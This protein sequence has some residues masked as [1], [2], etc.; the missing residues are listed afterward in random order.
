MTLQM[1]VIRAACREMVCANVSPAH[2]P[3]DAANEHPEWDL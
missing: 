2:L 1:E 3:N